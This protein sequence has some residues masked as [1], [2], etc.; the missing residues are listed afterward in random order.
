MDPKACKRRLQWLQAEYHHI[1][2]EH[3]LPPGEDTAAAAIRDKPH[4]E[5]KRF[6]IH[7]VNLMR[8]AIDGISQSR[9]PYLDE[10]LSLNMVSQSC[11]AS[12]SIA[13]VLQP[14]E[15]HSGDEAVASWFPPMPPMVARGP[16]YEHR[17]C[18]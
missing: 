7:V 9:N 10:D 2:V 4:D 1:C 13:R 5:L 6:A 3:R 8:S 12:L 18:Q 14:I 15:R 11:I 16:F 17:Q